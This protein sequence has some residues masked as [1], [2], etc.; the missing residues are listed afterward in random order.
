VA[1]SNGGRGWAYWKQLREA[2]SQMSSVFHRSPAIGSARVNRLLRP[3][4]LAGGVMAVVLLL[5]QSGIGNAQAPPPRFPSIF[6]GEARV[7]GQPVPDGLEVTA[8]IGD[9]ES[10]PVTVIDGQYVGLKI[11]PPDS[12]AGGTI[13]FHLHRVKA[14]QTRLFRAGEIDLSFDLTFPSL[15]EPTPT[16]T[17][18]PPTPTATAEAAFP[19]VYSGSL[20]V[21]GGVVPR[22][23]KLVARI[24]DYESTPGLIEGEEY[25]NLVVAPGDGRLVGRKVEFFLGEFRADTTDVYE[26]G[27]FKTGFALIFV[28]LPDPTPT[29]TPTATGTPVPPPTPTATARPTATTPAPPTLTSTPEP[30]ATARATATATSTSVP[31]T[32]TATP[33]PPTLTSTPEATA[34]ATATSTPVPPT[35]TATPLPP[36]A[37][38]TAVPP[39]PIPTETP[40]PEGGGCFAATSVAPGTAAANAILMFAPVALLV[41]YRRLRL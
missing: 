22:G 14:N 21:A 24:G 9:Y 4:V 36:T 37:T 18:V 32:S 6:S 12:I 13:T 33:L 26:S 28:G 30:T 5:A 20:V 15:P 40:V 11:A 7:G 19:A 1:R 16:V 41:G 8:R 3:T 17:P 23:A 29:A 2:N 25:R 39:P 35:S 10:Q 38:S 27:A 31:P 34:T